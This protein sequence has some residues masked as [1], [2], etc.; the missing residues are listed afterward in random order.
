MLTYPNIDPIALEIGPVAIHWYGLMYIVGFAAAWGLGR[1]RA[2][3]A[4]SPVTPQQVD[5]LIFFG[6][7]GV[8]L[9]AK[10]GY[11]LFYNF[12]GLLNDPLALLR[13]WEGG[14]SFHGGLIGVTLMLVLY[15]WRHQIDLLRLAD[16]GAPLVP[17]GLGAGRLGNFING[18][19]WGRASDV[20]WAMVYEPL[21][22]E[23]RH[24]SQLYQMG[25]EGIALFIL[26][27][28]FSAK[29]RPRGAIAGLFL[30]AYG[31]FRGFVEFFRMPDDHIGYLAFGWLT[32]GH[33]L[34]LPMILIGCGL[35]WW[36]YRQ[37]LKN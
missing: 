7:I 16:F 11:H 20:P 30:A 8:V 15:A 10:I 13:L 29:P 37:R 22:P 1:W 17:I 24:P 4:D 34:T 36:A 27:W 2:K 23:P 21:G 9:G 25:L 28:W 19:L 26:L 12:T 33:L 3:R 35:I 6:A 18:E 5:D 14:M 32:M 31:I